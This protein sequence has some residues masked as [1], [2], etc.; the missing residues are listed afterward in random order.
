MLSDIH[1][2]NTILGGGLAG[3]P[4]EDITKGIPYVL[5]RTHPI[6]DYIAAFRAAQLTI[7]D[8]VEPPIGEVQ[9][10]ALPSYA[11]YPEATR[12]AFEGLPYLLIWRLR[13][14]GMSASAPL[15]Q[16]V[17]PI[18]GGA[19]GEELVDVEHAKDRPDD[20][21]HSLSARVGEAAGLDELDGVPPVL[22]SQVPAD[23]TL[24]TH[25]APAPYVSA[26]TYSSLRRNT[27]TGVR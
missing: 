27:F 20:G 26:T 13:R 22:S 5:N 16:P 3:F 23:S 19:Q 9:L 21:G 10:R 18:G 14:S 8:C 25:S 11:F 4:D 2:L 7:V 1:P 15:G 17:T 24:R 6:A 12:R